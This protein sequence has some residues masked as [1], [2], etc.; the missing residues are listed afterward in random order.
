MSELSAAVLLAV[1]AAIGWSLFDLERRYLSARVE[2][3]ALV[4]WVTLGAL[5]PLAIWA[6]ASGAGGVRVAERRREFW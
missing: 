2:A 3:M 5:P 1:A 4:A 6:L